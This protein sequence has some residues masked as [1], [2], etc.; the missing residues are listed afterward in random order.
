MVL[1]MDEISQNADQLSVLAEQL[2][3]EIAVFKI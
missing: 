3:Q 2:N 1:T